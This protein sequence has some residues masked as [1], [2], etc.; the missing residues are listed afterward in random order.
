MPCASARVSVTLPSLATPPG[1]ITRLWDA[2][3]CDSVVLGGK[4][5][6]NKRKKEDKVRVK[7]HKGMAME[8]DGRAVI[9]RLP[10][11]SPRVERHEPLMVAVKI[12]STKYCM[13]VDM[14]ATSL[15]HF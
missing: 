15:H 13:Q 2:E 3:E 12:C 1:D 7:S 14:T 8:M 4:L 5:V 9:R 10:V 6:T 11:R